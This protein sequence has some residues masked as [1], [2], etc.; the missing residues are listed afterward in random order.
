MKPEKDQRMQRRKK[1]E[2]ATCKEV[3]NLC[4][5]VEN[6]LISKW[7]IKDLLARLVYLTAAQKKNNKQ[8][9]SRHVLSRWLRVTHSRISLKTTACDYIIREEW[10]RVGKTMQENAINTAQTV[11]HAAAR[12]YADTKILF[13]PADR[14]QRALAN[15]WNPRLV[16]R[17]VSHAFL[18]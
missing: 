7:K 15:S 13:R 5:R 16:A 11:A 2:S 6:S 17:K 18:L 9:S 3:K 10:K 8:F 14:L 12:G 4:E 1:V